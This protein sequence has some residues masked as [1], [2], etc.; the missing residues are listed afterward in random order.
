MLTAVLSFALLGVCA[1]ARIYFLKH[2][3]ALAAAQN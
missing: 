1:A 2:M 3:N